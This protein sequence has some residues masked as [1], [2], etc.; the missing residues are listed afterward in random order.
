MKKH[1]TNPL[2][3]ARQLLETGSFLE[4]LEKADTN[5]LA[6]VI[7][8][9]GEDAAKRL[10]AKFCEALPLP[11]ELPS[12]LGGVRRVG[13]EPAKGKLGWRQVADLDDHPFYGKLV[14]SVI[15]RR[16]SPASDIVLG[17]LQRSRTAMTTP[18]SVQ[19]KDPKRVTVAERLTPWEIAR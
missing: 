2:A 13:D 3:M 16:G 1:A 4:I 11:A 7:A 8:E 18:A 12:L 10:D 6:R 5:A 17:C 9:D 14:L 19:D 15:R